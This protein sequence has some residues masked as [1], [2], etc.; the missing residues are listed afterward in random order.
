M[1]LF[2]ELPTFRRTRPN[3]AVGKIVVELGFRRDYS[4]G[5]GWRS[6][7]FGIF[8]INRI[9]EPGTYFF[10]GDHISGFRRQ[11]SVWLPVYRE[12]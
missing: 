8:R 6:L 3:E 12:L 1:H 10:R 5:P 9:A 2:R 4:A 7:S 11:Y